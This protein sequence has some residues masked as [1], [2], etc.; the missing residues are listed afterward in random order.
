MARFK[1]EAPDKLPLEEAVAKL[2]EIQLGLKQNLTWLHEKLAT[3]DSGSTVQFNLTNIQRDAEMRASGL[4]TEVKALREELRSI[5]E[6]LGLNSE[7][8]NRI[9]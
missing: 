9:N 1:E 8:K 2:Q 5:R 3:L 7:K 6:L 4:E